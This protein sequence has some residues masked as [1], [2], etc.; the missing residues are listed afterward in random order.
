M[1]ATVALCLPPLLICT[2][3]GSSKLTGNVVKESLNLLGHIQI[4]MHIK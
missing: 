3:H 4:A 1:W 2:Q